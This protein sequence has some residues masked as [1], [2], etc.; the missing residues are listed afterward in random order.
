MYLIAYLPI[1]DVRVFAE[2]NYYLDTLK[3]SNLYKII[4]KKTLLLYQFNVV[5]KNISFKLNSSTFFYIT[6]M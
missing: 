1:N 6:N 3:W 5:W 4:N 2:N